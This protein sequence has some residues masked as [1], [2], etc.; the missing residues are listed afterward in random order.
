MTCLVKINQK[1]DKINDPQTLTMPSGQGWLNFFTH[2]PSAKLRLILQLVKMVYKF[3]EVSRPIE[4]VHIYLFLLPNPEL[5][6]E[7]P[8]F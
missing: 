1:S 7:N 5:R 4:Y 3:L 8:Y 2:L 6:L